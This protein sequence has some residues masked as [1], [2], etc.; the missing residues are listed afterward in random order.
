MVIVAY[1]QKWPRQFEKLKHEITKTVT[2]Y[3]NIEHIGSTSIPGMYAKPIIDINIGI[4]K[5]DDFG[6][7]KDELAR[8]GY[9]HNGDHG[10]EGR[11]VFNRSGDCAHGVLD[12]IKHHLYV[13]TWDSREFRRN[14]LLRDYL[15]R[16]ADYV[17]QYNRIKLEILEKYGENNRAKYVEVKERDYTWFFED[18]IK[19]SMVEK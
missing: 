6:P 3:K 9:F 18:V 11:E 10:I 15:R 17:E 7:I 4:D 1:D 5:I 16:H 2:H 14:L 12:S 13:G 8:L 19:K